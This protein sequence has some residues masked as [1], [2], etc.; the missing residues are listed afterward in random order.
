MQNKLLAHTVRSP[1][2]DPIRQCTFNP[3]SLVPADVT[4]RRVGRP[5]DNWT[6]K[7]YE[8]MFIINNFGI[9]QQFKDQP[10]PSIARMEPKIRDRS[11]KTK[12][13]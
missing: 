3:N 12:K 6:W 1:N 9:K 2:D 11:I 5:R 10:L 7:C 13:E 4:K 8:D